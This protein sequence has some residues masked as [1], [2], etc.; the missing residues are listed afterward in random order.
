MRRHHQDKEPSR[1]EISEGDLQKL[2]EE[3]KASTLAEKSKELIISVLL[4]FLWLNQQLERK[5]ISLKKLFRL[6]FGSKTEK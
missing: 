1:I 2:I 3:I 5:T 6:L 4:S